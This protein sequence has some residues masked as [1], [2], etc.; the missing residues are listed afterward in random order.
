M[1]ST[2]STIASPVLLTLSDRIPSIMNHTSENRPPSDLPELRARMRRDLTV[3][4]KARQA[5]V[6]SALR[7]ALAA[8]DNA[9]AVD[10]PPGDTVTASGPVAG[11]QAGVGSTEAARRVLSI[12]EVYAL[13]ET[14]IAERV[15][16]ADQYDAHGR[17]DM[18]DRLRREAGILRS[19]VPG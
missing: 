16:A 7:T 11:A 4:M 10:V 13:L 6:V 12:E 2:L 15:A 1:T 17:H 19:Y 3:A 18:A 8:I 5:D 14:Q 9:E